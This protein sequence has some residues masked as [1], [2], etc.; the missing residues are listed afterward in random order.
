[1]PFVDR[2]VT[3]LTQIGNRAIN[4]PL[5]SFR[6]CKYIFN[7]LGTMFNQQVLVSA[8]SQDPLMRM[9]E[10]VTKVLLDGQVCPSLLLSSTLSKN[11]TNG[12]IAFSKV[13]SIF[14]E[15]VL[16]SHQK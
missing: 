15:A 10:L 7:T 14:G 9:F 11:N 6:M 4:N 2:L 3:A 5:P 1:V 8:V 16:R 12:H 13:L